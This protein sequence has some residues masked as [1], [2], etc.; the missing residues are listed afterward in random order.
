MKQ[1]HL[2]VI[3][4]LAVFCGAATIA[5]AQ[6]P[7][8]QSQTK[9][10]EKS[11]DALAKSV[12]HQ[13]QVLP[14]YSVFDNIESRVDGNRVIL[15]GQVLRST[16]KKHA[17][18]AVTDLEGVATVSNQIEVLPAS[19]SDD[20]LRTAIYRVLFEDGTLKK[21]AAESVPPIH[22]VVKDGNVVLVGVVQNE[23][24]RKLAGTLASQVANS[25]SLQNRVTVRSK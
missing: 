5:S 9:A 3:V 21:Y 23:P 22:I 14:F 18:A 10:P 16:L 25:K 17:E 20:D 13:I 15:S 7:A 6:P 11:S 4:S 19:S 2:A 12:R 24:D 8:P 1:L